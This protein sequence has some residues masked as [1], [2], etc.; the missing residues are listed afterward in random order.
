MKFLI[1]TD[2]EGAW[3]VS[4]MES[5][6]RGDKDFTAAYENLAADINAAVDG[7]IPL[8]EEG[9][10]V[11]V[12]DGHGEQGLNFGLV[13]ERATHGRLEALRQPFD[14][15][16][17]IGFHAMAGTQNAFLDHTQSSRSWFDYRIN[18]RPTGEIGQSAMNAANFDAPLI[19]V[20]GDE[21]A[22]REAYDFLGNIECVAV[23]RATGRNA[24][25]M[26]DKEET[27][28]KIK[29][30]SAGA[31]KR[32]KEDPK[33]F[34]IYKPALPA[35]MLLTYMRSDFCDIAMHYN[36]AL[37]R[38]DARTV[39]KIITGYLDILP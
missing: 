29:L 12:T 30:A 33:S 28:Q 2:L 9:D 18:G 39:R 17:C 11:I 10:E 31:V 37:E 3:G 14:A 4:T 1:E 6:F 32:F 23:K 35:E 21:A 38:I 26:Y 22:V 8:L 24:C 36:P 13:D 16:I 27:R 25:I 34:R 7:I 5:V 19:M 15:M 20:T